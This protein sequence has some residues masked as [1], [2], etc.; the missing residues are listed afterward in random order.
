MDEEEGDF[1][2]PDDVSELSNESE[3]LDEE[4]SDSE[5]DEEE[6]EEEDE[7]GNEI[8]TYEKLKKMSWDTFEEAL[9]MCNAYAQSEGF[10]LVKNNSRKCPKT[11]TVVYKTLCCH[12]MKKG[13]EL[14]DLQKR[15]YMEIHATE[16][17]PEESL[18]NEGEV[19]EK[20]SECNCKFRINLQERNS[21][22]VSNKKVWRLSVNGNPETQIHCHPMLPRKLI[23]FSAANRRLP[24]N[25]KN[26][27][28]GLVKGTFKMKAKEVIDSIRNNFPEYNAISGTK[29]LLRADVREIIRNVRKEQNKGDQALNIFH[30]FQELNNNGHELFVEFTVEGNLYSYT[31]LIIFFLFYFFLKS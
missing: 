19:S 13:N 4:L 5:D 21:E 29:P 15:K 1:K 11:N 26:H 12:K 28:E 24:D 23:C 30:A 25:V 17:L 22:D 18:E 8:I 14:K 27:I 31:C 9:R 7:F 10:F 2:I 3:K 20:I 6:K 16:N